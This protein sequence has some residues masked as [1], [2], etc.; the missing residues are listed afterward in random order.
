[1]PVSKV[2]KIMGVYSQRLWNVFKYWVSKVHQADEIKNLTQVGFDETS[3]KKG[4]N[5]VTIAVDLKQRRVLFATFGKGSECIE[6]AVDYLI[7]KKYW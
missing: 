2:A 7:E 4:H 5:Y 3:S 1:M 6:Q